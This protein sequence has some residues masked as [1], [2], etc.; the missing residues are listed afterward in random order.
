MARPRPWSVLPGHPGPAPRRQPG[1][2]PPSSQPAGPPGRAVRLRAPAP[3]P[4]WAGPGAT[5]SHWASRRGL[6]SRG[7]VPFRPRPPGADSDGGSRGSAAGAAGVGG[8]L[9]LRAPTPGWRL[10]G[11]RSWEL[12]GIPLY[13]GAA[14]LEEGRR[15]RDCPQISQ[16]WGTGRARGRPLTGCQPGDCG[17]ELRTCPWGSRPEE[18]S[19]PP[20]VGCSLTRCAAGP[21]VKSS[22]LSR[23]HLEAGCGAWE[24]AAPPSGARTGRG[25]P[26]VA[27]GWA[28][29][30]WSLGQDV[31]GEELERWREPRATTLISW[32]GAGRIGLAFQCLAAQERR[33]EQTAHIHVPLPCR[34]QLENE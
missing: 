33:K 22:V 28:R 18:S 8:G 29:G 34:S 6:G 24:L 23:E 27:Q 13:A 10:A 9:E 14:S 16:A 30:T 31:L 1:L 32:E 12:P 3:P 21:A 5:R 19:G 25:L 4:S 20:W 17:R 26:A 2:P 7:R 11:P 15:A